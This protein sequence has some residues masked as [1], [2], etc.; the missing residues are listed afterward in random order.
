MGFNRYLVV[1]N[2]LDQIHLTLQTIWQLLTDLEN[3]MTF[4]KMNI[5]HTS[6][7]KPKEL[8]SIVKIM[9]QH[10]FENQLLYVND[11]EIRHYYDVITLD[12]YYSNMTMYSYSMF[13]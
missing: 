4:S 3:T 8:Q 5:V 10:Y 6:I 13:L 2:V 11:S 7:L 12:A 9:K 1:K